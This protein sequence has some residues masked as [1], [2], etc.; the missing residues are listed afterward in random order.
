M[1][2][3]RRRQVVKL[4]VCMIYVIGVLVIVRGIMRVSDSFVFDTSATDIRTEIAGNRNDDEIS[5]GFQGRWDRE[6]IK[7]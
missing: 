2:S 7:R 1:I 3:R 5:S 6:K 4:T